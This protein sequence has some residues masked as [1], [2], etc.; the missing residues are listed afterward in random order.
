MF[1]LR[2]FAFLQIASDLFLINNE[3]TV[4]AFVFFYRNII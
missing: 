4:I 3:N 2:L 1:I